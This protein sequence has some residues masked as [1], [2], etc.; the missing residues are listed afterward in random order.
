[1]V[2]RLYAC[3]YEDTVPLKDKSFAFNLHVVC[4]SIEQHVV[5]HT[6]LNASV[7]SLYV[8]GLQVERKQM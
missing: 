3:I 6:N 5:T 4:K 8:Q 1:M 7:V 2:L